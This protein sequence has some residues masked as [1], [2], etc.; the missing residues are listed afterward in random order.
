MRKNIFGKVLEMGR[1]SKC[2]S[3]EMTPV[4]VVVFSKKLL[5]D[6]RRRKTKKKFL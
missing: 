6:E 1:I 2:Y 4:V 5:M 3:I